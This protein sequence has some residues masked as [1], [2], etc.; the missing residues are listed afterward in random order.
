MHVAR[1]NCG[2]GFKELAERAGGFDYI[3]V[4][5]ALRRFRGRLA[6]NRSLRDAC[7]QVRQMINKCTNE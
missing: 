2:I 4:A 3:S 5:T 7:E 1:Q 6:A